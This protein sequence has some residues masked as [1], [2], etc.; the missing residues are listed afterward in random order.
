MG[1][2][3]VTP[4]TAGLKRRGQ[5]PSGDSGSRRPLVRFGGAWTFRGR[6]G[7]AS[8]NLARVSPDQRIN[9]GVAGEPCRAFKCEVHREAGGGPRQIVIGSREIKMRR[10]PVTWAFLRAHI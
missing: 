7:A 8:A 4:A 1:T 3:L 9:A 5:G 6:G 10:K 2:P